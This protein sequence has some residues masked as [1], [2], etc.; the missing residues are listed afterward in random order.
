MHYPSPAYDGVPVVGGITRLGADGTLDRSFDV[1]SALSGT[2]GTMYTASVIP[3]G[4]DRLYVAGSF[5]SFDGL[6]ENNVIRLNPN[7]SVDT[8]FS[9]PA[10]LDA[11]AYF[12][13]ARE[14][15]GVLVSGD[16]TKGLLAL[17]EHGNPLH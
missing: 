8:S 3:D 1:G 4:S 10:D 16:F 7:G 13:V 14:G 12:A 11:V 2:A 6:A 5:K 17:D 9:G 15:G